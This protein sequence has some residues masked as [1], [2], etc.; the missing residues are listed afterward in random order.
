MFLP[1]ELQEYLFVGPL[2]SKTHI[3]N[4]DTALSFLQF[5]GEELRER[6]RRLNL[7][8]SDKALVICDQATQHTASKYDELRHQWCLQHNCVSCTSLLALFQ[9]IFVVLRR[10]YLLTIYMNMDVQGTML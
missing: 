2:Q 9:R 1:Q 6:R 8:H 3:W 7:S 4:A 10:R 5:L